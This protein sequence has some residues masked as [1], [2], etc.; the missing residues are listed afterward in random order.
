MINHNLLTVGNTTPVNITSGYDS[1]FDATIQ[2]VNSAGY[3]YIG[4]PT[5]SSTSYGFRLAPNH[6]F[7]IELSGQ[8]DLYVIGSSQ[9]MNVAILLAHLEAGL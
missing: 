1:G 2:N 3:I 8:D 6:A 5:V 9:N 7:S 4:G